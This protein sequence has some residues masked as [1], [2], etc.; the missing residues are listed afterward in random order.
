MPP[1]LDS[2]V[3]GRP[4]P[5]ECLETLSGLEPEDGRQNEIIQ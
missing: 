4:L 5:A 3:P 2:G 1:G